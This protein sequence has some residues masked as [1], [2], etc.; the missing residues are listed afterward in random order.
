MVQQ[1]AV[2]TGLQEE[3]D[4]FT[5]VVG[6][7]EVF[8]ITLLSFFLWFSSSRAVLKHIVPPS[9]VNLSN[10]CWNAATGSLFR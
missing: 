1:P 10:S 2:G 9:A 8:T 6:A 3:D 7:C 4:L 5:A